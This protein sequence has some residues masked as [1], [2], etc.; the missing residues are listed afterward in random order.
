MKIDVLLLLD[1]RFREQATRGSDDRVIPSSVE[2]FVAALMGCRTPRQ[3]KYSFTNAL[4]EA[5]DSNLSKNGFVLIRDLVHN[6]AAGKARLLQTPCFPHGNEPTI[7][8]EPKS[9]SASSKVSQDPATVL[10]LE[11]TV[12]IRLENDL[13]DEIIS[14]PTRFVPK[15]VSGI[16]VT[17]LVNWAASL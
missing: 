3:G 6:L 4:L 8:L 5:I 9:P 11:M 10:I 17:K 2:L 7:R 16:K 15:D 1:C 13:L 12:R 14:W